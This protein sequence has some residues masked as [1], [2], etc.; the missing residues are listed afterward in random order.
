VSTFGELFEQAEQEIRA[1]I[2]SATAEFTNY[3]V[4]QGAVL[5]ASIRLWVELCEKTETD[6]RAMVESSD[7]SSLEKV[8]E[9][10]AETADPEGVMAS[11]LLKAIVN[12]P[13][14]F[15]ADAR[16]C[17]SR[18]FAG[19]KG[20]RR[21]TDPYDRP[22]PVLWSC[23]DPNC[24]PSA[25]APV[26]VTESDEEAGAESERFTTDEVAALLNV[27]LGTIHK[28][29]QEG[30]GPPGY[31]THKES[32]YRRSDV[33]RWL[34]EQGVMLAVCQSECGGT[35]ALNAFTTAKD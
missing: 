18:A 14:S 8:V 1:H 27:P 30:T 12:R 23:P 4:V 28:W 11:Q 6:E 25:I 9:D 2:E 34:A 32:R 15:V 5:L 3:F 21:S 7:K 33:V 35:Y 17:A 13:Q 19:E 10:L 26:D 24:P 29:H 31:Q 20:E 22:M 16:H